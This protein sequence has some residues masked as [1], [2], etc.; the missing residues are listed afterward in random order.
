MLGSK[1]EILSPMLFLLFKDN[2]HM[3]IKPSNILLFVDDAKLF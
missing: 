3:G 2:S 1:G